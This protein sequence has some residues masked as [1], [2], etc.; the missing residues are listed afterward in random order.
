MF[1]RPTTRLQGMTPS[2]VSAKLDAFAPPSVIT[3]VKVPPAGSVV[4]DTVAPKT[5]ALNFMSFV[6]SSLRAQ[7]RMMETNTTRCCQMLSA[8][9][10]LTRT[11]QSSCSCRAGVGRGD[12]HNRPPNS[13]RRRYGASGCRRPIRFGRFWGSSYCRGDAKPCCVP[14]RHCG[15]EQRGHCGEHSKARDCRHHQRANRVVLQAGVFASQAEHASNVPQY[16]GAVSARV[17][18]KSKGT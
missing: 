13:F 14:F 16:P 8:S 7:A 3:P 4:T 5:K 9:S 17:R 15:A 2:L 12:K 10:R 6:P 1:A 11:T 18:S